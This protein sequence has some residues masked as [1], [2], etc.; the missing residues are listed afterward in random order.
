VRFQRVGRG[1]AVGVYYGFLAAFAAAVVLEVLVLTIGTSW[2]P[3]VSAAAAAVFA[4]VVCRSALSFVTVSDGVVRVRNPF[5]SYAFPVES[6]RSLE[7]VRITGQA[8]ALR[9][10]LTPPRRRVVAVALTPEDASSFREAI[11]HDR[12]L[13]KDS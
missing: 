13:E 9:L 11:S 12:P 5:R 8:S 10:E 2:W 3:E 4:L 1:A 7:R 6:V